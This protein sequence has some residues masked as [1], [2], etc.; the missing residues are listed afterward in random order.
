MPAVSSVSKGKASLPSWLASIR[1]RLP[2]CWPSSPVRDGNSY[3]S[4]TRAYPS[5][6]VAIAGHH[7][8]DD[9]YLELSDSRH[10]END[11]LGLVTTEIQGAADGQR[12]HE[13]G[14][15]QKSIAIHQLTR[16][17]RPAT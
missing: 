6:E 7:G 13:E 17:A 12:T 10:A 4:E 14:V 5:D 1:S 3:L 8:G 9:G 11:E 15:V 16:Q 2:K